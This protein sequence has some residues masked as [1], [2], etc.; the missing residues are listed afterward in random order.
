LDLDPDSNPGLGPGFEPWT[1]T[2][3]RTPDLD[4]DSS[5]R[6]SWTWTRIRALGGPGLGPGFEP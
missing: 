1:W 2:R 6:G 5:P 4:P 3:I